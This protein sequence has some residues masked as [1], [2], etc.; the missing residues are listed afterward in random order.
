MKIFFFSVRTF[1]HDSLINR[2]FKRT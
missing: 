2:K 1:F